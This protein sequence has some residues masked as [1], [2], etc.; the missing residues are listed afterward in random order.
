MTCKNTLT[1]WNKAHL[2]HCLVP[3]RQG[4]SIH[5]LNSAQYHSMPNN[6][7]VDVAIA[8]TY[9]HCFPTTGGNSSTGAVTVAKIRKFCGFSEKEFDKFHKKMHRLNTVYSSDILTNN[10][11]LIE[12][13]INK[14]P[15]RYKSIERLAESIRKGTTPFNI[16]SKDN[17]LL[18]LLGKGKDGKPRLFC[19]LFYSDSPY[20]NT[21]GYQGGG[22]NENQIQT[23][24]ERLVNASNN[25]SHFIFSC[26]ASKSIE[27]SKFQKLIKI[28]GNLKDFKEL[29]DPEEIYTDRT[30]IEEATYKR[31]DLSAKRYL[32]DAIKLLAENQSIYQNIFSVFNLYSDKLKRKYYVLVCLE[33]NRFDKINKDVSFSAALENLMPIEVFITD[34]DYLCPLDCN[35]K[36]RKRNYKFIKYEISE[37]CK[38]LDK[39]MFKSTKTPSIESNSQGNY[40]LK[41]SN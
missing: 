34:Y 36:Q 4:N 38:K 19:T 27:D 5:L 41:S 35:D 33:K 31:K 40:T 30:Y 6:D 23:L 13:Y 18:R 20:L 7:K 25:G 1:Q 8:Y 21:A 12:Y 32:K 28:I 29:L 24:I 39:H 9:L 2:Q 11:S 10:S 16:D 22:I 14:A 37:F 3:C 26:R 17:E 15:K